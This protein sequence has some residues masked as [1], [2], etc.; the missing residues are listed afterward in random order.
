[1]FITKK[2]TLGILTSVFL[3]GCSNI[4][5]VFS[6]KNYTSESVGED[7]DTY[8]CEILSIAPVTVKDSDINNDIVGGILGGALGG[9]VGHQ[10]G[11]GSGKTAMTIIGTVAGAAGGS[12]LGSAATKAQKNNAYQYV[13]KMKDSG[14]LK[15]IVQGVKPKFN[16]GENVYLLIGKYNN[17]T[18]KRITRS[19]LVKKNQ[20]SNF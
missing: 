17:Y 16:V 20:V 12:A 9:V 10:L 8:E 19:R 5:D 2:F 18:G 14:K 1:M 6:S 3:I 4:S 13:V 15:T 11:G 7:I